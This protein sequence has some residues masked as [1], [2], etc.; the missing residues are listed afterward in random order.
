MGRLAEIHQGGGVDVDIVEARADGLAHQ[1]LHRIHFRRGRDR[2]LLVVHLEMVAL[3]EDRRAMAFPQRGGD[4]HRDVFGRP[5]LRIG[6]L[7][8]RDLEDERAGLHAE[9]GAEDRPGGVVRRSAHIDRGDGESPD[10]P[11]SARHVQI[12]DGRGPHAGRLA[13]LPDQPAR[14]LTCQ[15]LSKHRSSNELVH[16]RGGQRL[17]SRDG[18]TTVRHGHGVAEQ[19]VESVDVVHGILASARP[20]HGARKSR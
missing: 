16:L 1:R 19:G 20:P 4:H 7:G 10:L 14:I 2:I 8:A 3:N 9:G 12:V 11:S 18:H 17:W 13:Q 15:R 6:D 5:L